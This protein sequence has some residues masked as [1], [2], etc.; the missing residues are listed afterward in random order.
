MTWKPERHTALAPMIIVSG[1]DRVIAFAEAAFGARR[2]GEP[3]LRSDGRIWNAAV[4]VAGSTVLLSDGGEEMRYPAFLH[5]YVEDVDAAFAAALAAGGTEMMPISEQFYGDRAGGVSDPCGN[6]W[7]LATQVR[8]MS[9]EELT[10][11]AREAE[12]TQ[13]A[14]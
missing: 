6:I 10:A 9:H 2:L 14:Q 7:W 3:L 8:N 5:L 12:T 1:V 4:E 13:G 11:A